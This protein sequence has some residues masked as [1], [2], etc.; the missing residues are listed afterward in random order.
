M[1]VNDVQN[2]TLLL[3][4]TS[5]QIPSKSTSVLDLI[6]ARYRKSAGRKRDLIL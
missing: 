5:V 6:Q 3:L 4:S 1:R 2:K